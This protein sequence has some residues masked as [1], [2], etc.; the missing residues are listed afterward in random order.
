MGACLAVVE[1]TGMRKNLMRVIAVV[2]LAFGVGIGAPGGQAWGVSS[3]AGLGIWLDP[4]A[5]SVVP[6]GSVVTTLH[7]DT[8]PT[9]IFVAGLPAGVSIG[10]GSGRPTVFRI[11]I[12]TAAST[13]PGVYLIRFGASGSTATYTLTV[14]G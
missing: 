7:T 4:A 1:E 3:E 13:V 5:G 6:G 9:G 8:A 2:V 11:S 12:N 10:L 14:I